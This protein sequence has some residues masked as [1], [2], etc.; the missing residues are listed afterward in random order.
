M[1]TPNYLVLV[2]TI[3]T[4][5]QLHNH[6]RDRSLPC[7]LKIIF[8]R[9]DTSL[10]LIWTYNLIVTVSTLDEDGTPPGH[11]SMAASTGA[12]PKKGK[13]TK[14]TNHSRYGLLLCSNPTPSV[15]GVISSPR[16]KV[17]RVS[18]KSIGSHVC[19]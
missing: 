5:G 6:L 18:R 3:E 1:C 14:V 13:K 8:F 2:I 11:S 10:M 16:A 19:K 12:K 15:E 7:C 17:R 9:S 4:P